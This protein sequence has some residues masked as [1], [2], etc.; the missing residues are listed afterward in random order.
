MINKMNGIQKLEKIS[1]SITLMRTKK[2]LQKSVWKI[3]NVFSRLQWKNPQQ[4]IWDFIT[5]ALFYSALPLAGDKLI[6][7]AFRLIH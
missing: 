4:E 1:L 2:S 7:A 5:L 3:M 6:S